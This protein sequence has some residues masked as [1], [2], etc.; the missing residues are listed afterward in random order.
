MFK[1]LG[2]RNGTEN[3][4]KVYRFSD[5]CI[6]IGSCRYSQPWTG[7]LPSA[8]NVLTKTPN[9]SSNTRGDIFQ[10]NF[11]ENDKKTWQKCSH[12]NS[13][14]ICDAFTCSL[15]KRVLKRRFLESGLTK[16]FTVCNFANT[17]TVTIMFF[18]KCLKF[19]VDSGNGTKNQQKVYRFSDNCIWIGSCRFSQ[20][21]TGYLP[22]TG[23]VLTNTSNISPNTRG[24]IFQINFTEND[25]KTW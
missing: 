6:W 14:S 5:N 24:D 19:D 4:E 2:S 8:V 3:Q 15:S 18:S 22:S 7:Y 1:D 16:I 23:N 25:K 17:L 10:I 11:P 9:I 20:D 21:W 13:R 12:G